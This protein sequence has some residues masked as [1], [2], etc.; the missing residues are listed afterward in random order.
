MISFDTKLSKVFAAIF[1]ISLFFVMTTNLEHPD[2]YKAMFISCSICFP[3]F[4]LAWFFDK[5][6]N[7]KGHLVASIV[8]VFYATCSAIHKTFKFIKRCGRFVKVLVKETTKNI[9][10]LYRDAV[11]IKNTST[12]TE[13]YE[14]SLE[15]YNKHHS[16]YNTRIEVS[17]NEQS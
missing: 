7:I 5:P 12:Y 8:T 6:R 14:D 2:G 10:T 1:F 3:S 15:T 16:H 9:C 4:G 11:K 13:I 17:R